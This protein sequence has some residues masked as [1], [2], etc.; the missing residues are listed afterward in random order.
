M[1][2]YLK[3]LNA[4]RDNNPYVIDELVAAIELF[5]APAY[6]REQNWLYERWEEGDLPE[7]QWIYL[8]F[9]TYEL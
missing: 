2:K 1:D 4:V 3:K 5:G 8:D 7:G 6:G 9:L